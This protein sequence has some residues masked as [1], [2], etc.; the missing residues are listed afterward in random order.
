MARGLPAALICSPLGF[1]LSDGD[2]MDYRV[3]ELTGSPHE[4]GRR[5]A[6]ELARV[7]APFRRNPWED[8]HD[9]LQACAAVLRATHAPL[10]EEIA[11]FADALDLPPERGLFIRAARIPQG[12]SVLAWR[13]HDNR[14][15]V[16]RNYDFYVQMPT[17]HLLRTTAAGSLAHL[18][19]NGGLVG[20]R[21]DGVNERGLF[22]GLH[23]VMA[24][25]APHYAP[26]VPYHLMPR[27]AL[28]LCATTAEAVSLFRDIPQLASFN[29]SI[30]DKSGDFAQVE[31]YPGRAPAVHRSREIMATTNHYADSDLAQLIGRRPTAESRARQA[32]LC[33][34]VQEERGDP[35][36]R[37]AQAL[38]DHAT[39]LCCH[40]EFGTTLWSGLFDLSGER[41]AYAFGPPCVTPYREYEWPG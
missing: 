30:A 17:R 32:S 4:I 12:C 28:D 31:C 11:A 18:G 3:L 37:T 20:G 1:L 9:F 16:G 8:D 2:Y 7:P 23:K 40:K 22:I 39:P 5:L 33:A 19:M 14:V 29:Y 34:A 15:L 24:D 13:T 27:L 6:R 41:V 26:G 36:V 21:Y 38:S 25:Q 10:W 35:W